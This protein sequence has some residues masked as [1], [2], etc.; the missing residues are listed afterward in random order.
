MGARSCYKNLALQLSQV[1][2]QRGMQSF[3]LQHGA[4]HIP[5]EFASEEV[6]ASF[7]LALVWLRLRRSAFLLH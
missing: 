5:R 6:A 3:L 1:G 4:I 2:L 7:A